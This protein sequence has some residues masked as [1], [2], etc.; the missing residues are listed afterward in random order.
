VPGAI[1][2][3]SE[4]DLRRLDKY[5]GYPD[6]Y[7]RINITVF[8][9]NGEPVKAMTYIRSRQIETTPPSREYLTI[10]QQGY[11]DWDIV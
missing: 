2:K 5:E 8:D 1:Y 9:E 11:R 6:N 3:I 7:N 10:I 4:R